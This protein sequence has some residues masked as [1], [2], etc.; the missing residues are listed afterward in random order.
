MQTMRRTTGAIEYKDI[1]AS[2]M[3]VTN[4]RLGIVEG[5]FNRTGNVDYQLDRTLPGAWASPL[6]DAY[7]RK[8]AG[9]PYLVPFLWNHS[10][11][12]FPPG[13]VFF[14]EES[15]TGLFGKVQMNLEITSGRELYA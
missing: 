8:A 12:T 13:G 11:E 10:T 2:E 14:A 15:K 7:A 9:D 3:R 4:Q 1:D 5:Y 6:K